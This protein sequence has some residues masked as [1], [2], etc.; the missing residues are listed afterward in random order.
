MNYLK[1]RIKETQVISFVH[2]PSQTV[3]SLRE[4]WKNC[5]LHVFKF[6]F[7]SSM[8]HRDIDTIMN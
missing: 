8:P 3:T 7:L 6:W 5:I 4:K 2:N 1:F